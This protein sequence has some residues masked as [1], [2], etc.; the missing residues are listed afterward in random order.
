MLTDAQKEDMVIDRLIDH[1]LA[2]D[3]KISVH[4]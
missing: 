4:Y 1:L 3:L 2:N